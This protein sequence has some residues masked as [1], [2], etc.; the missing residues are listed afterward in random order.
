MGFLFIKKRIL[1]L[2]SIV[3][4][5]IFLSSPVYSDDTFKVCSECGKESDKKST[6]CIYCGIK[7]ESSK[8]TT[9]NKKG[10]NISDAVIQ[11]INAAQKVKSG[12]PA[13]SIIILRNAQALLLAE[14]S[15]DLNKELSE[16]IFKELNF[17]TSNFKRKN[18]ILVYQ[19][20][21]VLAQSAANDY[22]RSVGR[23]QLGRIWL[24]PE[25][26]DQLLPS[27]ISNIRRSLPP[28]CEDCDG[29]GMKQC[30]ECDGA[31]YLECDYNGCQ[32]GFIYERNPDSLSRKTELTRRRNC[33]LCDGKTKI[34]CKACKG[35]GMKICS[36][37]NGS[38]EA[39]ICEECAGLG[40][41]ACD[42]CERK[43][44]S[45]DC[46]YCKGERKKLC[47]ECG[48]DGKVK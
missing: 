46:V 17:I 48:G 26:L 22:F 10:F 2:N 38:A 47:S 7:F 24:P 12:N 30:K 18:S 3:C 8:S 44:N 37:C 6:E 16:K 45:S 28:P 27:D 34:K 40:L 41:E 23:T 21:I 43:G 13:L 15:N 20:K 4:A 9:D 5:F 36:D 1:W 32:N 35:V 33:P 39:P 29:I 25:W 11:D 19:N 42:K 31:S 14:P